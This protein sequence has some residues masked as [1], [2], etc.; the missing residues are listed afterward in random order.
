M[1]RTIKFIIPVLILVI[2]AGS[3]KRAYF[4]DGINEDPSK[5]HNPTPSSMLAG[6][7][8]TSAYNWG[9]D[10]SR[11][12]SLFTQQTTGAANQSANYTLYNLTPDDVDNMWNG[13]FYAGI[14]SNCDTMVKI[15]ISS[16]QL[17]Y[18]AVGMILLATNLGQVTDFWGDVPYSEAFRGLNNISP[19]YDKQQ[20]LYDTLHALLD[21]A[22]TYLSTDDGAAFQP[23]SGNDLIFGGDLDLW[24]RYA[25]SLKAKF[26]LH[27]VKV[28]ASAVTKALAQID[29]GFAAGEAAHI[30]FVGSAAVTTQ[31]PWFQFNDQRADISFEGYLNDIMAAAGD[32]RYDV[33]F[34]PSDNTLL[35]SLYGS[36][37]SPVYFMSYDEL[38]FIEAEAQFRGANLAAAATAYNA[39]VAANLQRTVGSTAYAATVAKTA[40]TITLKD[41]M[42][43]KYIALFLSPETWTDWRRTGYPT[44]TAPSGNVLNG[45]LPRSLYYPSS[46]VRY[47]TKTPSNTTLTRRVWWDAQ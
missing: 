24:I 11:F 9:G 27:T 16:G 39:A 30:K 10:A 40:A 36:A 28:N 5:L 34:D 6:V 23:G 35:G 41:I 7:E 12:A 42:V 29:D 20:A 1:L 3:C 25:H 15:A 43:Q 45:S 21:R 37:N 18:A 2:A 46:E 44:L 17:H 47:N 38:K 8:L 19:I 32:P 4:Y 13:G 22:I 31:N 33:Y 14:M 26:Y